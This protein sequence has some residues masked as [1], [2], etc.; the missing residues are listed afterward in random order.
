MYS[1]MWAAGSQQERQDVVEGQLTSGGFEE[2]HF[3]LLFL[4][5]TF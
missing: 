5:Y 1:E 4:P 2:N 3:L